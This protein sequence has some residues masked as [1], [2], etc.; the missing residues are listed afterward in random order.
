MRGWGNGIPRGFA[1]KNPYTNRLVGLRSRLTGVYYQ[2]DT[3][4]LGAAGEEIRAGGGREKHSLY[5]ENEARLDPSDRDDGS[6]SQN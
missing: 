6:G 1:V 3:P 4:F 5:R 2:N